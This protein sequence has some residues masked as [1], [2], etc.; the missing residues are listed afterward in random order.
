MTRTLKT[1]ITLFAAGLAMLMAS[2]QAHANVMTAGQHA[3]TNQLVHNTHLDK[4]V[5]SAWL[6]AEE[7]GWAARNRE[8]HHNH[9][10]LNIGYFDGITPP[11]NSAWRSPVKAALA[12]VAFMK[13]NSGGRSILRSA[14]KSRETQIRA[15]AN[16]HWA[17][18]G[19]NH[20]NVL[21][22]LIKKY[23]S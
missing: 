22:Y 15:I 18:N 13:K 11:K 9:N 7:S 4:K 19:Y 6:L 8:A 12:T 20:G 21:R 23:M 3:F 1:T 17:S 5:V 14:G 2:A 16:S 10:W